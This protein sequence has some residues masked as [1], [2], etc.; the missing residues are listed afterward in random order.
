MLGAAL[1]QP[2]RSLDAILSSGGWQ[3]RV[4][5]RARAAAATLHPLETHQLVS[6]SIRGH[7]RTLTLTAAATSLLRAASRRTASARRSPSPKLGGH[8]GLN[9]NLVSPA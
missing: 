6:L 2:R 3:L 1:R 5:P 7:Q 9:I 8:P 4:K